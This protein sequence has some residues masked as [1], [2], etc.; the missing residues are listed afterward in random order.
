MARFERRLRSTG[1]HGVF[2]KATQTQ[3]RGVFNINPA[4]RKLLR[5]FS[6]LF[7]YEDDQFLSGVFTPNLRFAP[8]HERGSSYF[9]FRMQ[10]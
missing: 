2:L 5:T 10:H 4:T 8:G 9:L 6:E 1:P 3:A 7:E